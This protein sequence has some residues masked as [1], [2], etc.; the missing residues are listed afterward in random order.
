MGFHDA[1]VPRGSVSGPDESSHLELDVFPVK[2]TFI[3]LQLKIP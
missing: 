1:F 3:D 2:M